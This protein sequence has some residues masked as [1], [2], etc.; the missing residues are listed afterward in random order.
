MWIEVVLLVVVAWFLLRKFKESK[1]RIFE[2]R[3]VKFDSFT[4]VFG[5]FKSMILKKK[6]FLDLM[7]ELYEKAAGNK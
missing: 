2:R 5:S 3:N 7:I 1:E 4:P 6:S